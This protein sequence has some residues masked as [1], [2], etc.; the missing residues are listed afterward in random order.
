MSLFFYKKV[1]EKIKQTFLS[2][3]FCSTKRK[4]QRKVALPHA[5]MLAEKRSSVA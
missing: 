2:T 3:F 1:P 5:N 4:L